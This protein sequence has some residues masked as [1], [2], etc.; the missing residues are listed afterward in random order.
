MTF[1]VTVICVNCD[2]TPEL[3]LLRNLMACVSPSRL[4]HWVYINWT[5]VFKFS[6]AP[7]WSSGGGG[8]T[9]YILCTTT[10]Y[11]SF[12]AVVT[13]L[14]CSQ[15][16]WCKRSLNWPMSWGWLFCV[17][18][19]LYPCWRWPSVPKG[20]SLWTP[21]SRR[22]L[23]SILHSQIILPLPTYWSDGLEVLRGHKSS[24]P[25]SRFPQGQFWISLCRRL[26]Y[27]G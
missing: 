27:V 13:T 7:W 5:I 1:I 25:L 19:L 20:W 24:Y 4:Y 23:S 2:I 22:K 18:T 6:I 21:S 26:I 9:P 12:P 3:E 16:P 15:W 17:S 10:E 11:P 14:L 8:G